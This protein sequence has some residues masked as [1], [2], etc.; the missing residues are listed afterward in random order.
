MKKLFF[1]LLCLVI[2]NSF[3]SANEETVLKAGY[4]KE[5]G[6]TPAVI[7]I[8]KLDPASTV[9]ELEEQKGT[10][11]EAYLYFI[12]PDGE[13]W[14]KKV[15]SYVIPVYEW[16]VNQPEKLSQFNKLEIYFN[17]ER[18]SNPFNVGYMNVKFTER[19]F[20]EEPV[21]AAIQV[22]KNGEVIP[23][24]FDMDQV[25]GAD[26][27]WVEIGVEEP[28]SIKV[29][30][31]NPDRGLQPSSISGSPI[32]FQGGTFKRMYSDI[33]NENSTGYDAGLYLE[34]PLGVED[35]GTFTK[36]QVSIGP[37]DDIGSDATL[38]AMN[39][40]VFLKTMTQEDRAAIAAKAKEAQK[41]MDKVW[42]IFYVLLAIGIV[43]SY[44]LV[45][46]I[47]KPRATQL[48]SFRFLW[49]L[50]GTRIFYTLVSVGWIAIV[51]LLWKSPLIPGNAISDLGI[52]MISFLPIIFLVIEPL[53]L[54]KKYKRCSNCK[55][56]VSPDFIGT[57]GL[58]GSRTKHTAKLGDERISTGTETHSYSADHFECPNCGADMSRYYSMHSGG[59]ADVRVGNDGKMSTDL[60]NTH[61]FFNFVL[62][63]AQ[64][65]K[66]Y[67]FYRKIGLLK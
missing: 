20:V 6:H 65:Y 49:L 22:T 33:L 58:G 28:V 42:N 55:A 63:L 53:Q 5:E 62:N 19:P 9:I 34:Q 26:F 60:M 64:P 35:R 48:A 11:H 37:S 54:D 32:S 41:N 27:V 31:T 45:R 61:A 59:K 52:L 47:Y 56:Y 67:R 43:G 17:G 40:T 51:W 12:K 8:S 14:S 21:T 30:R 2:L 4:D 23:A 66:W 16:F 15:S 25:R 24:E 46:L 10:Y 7:E 38:P 1:V 13:E 36:V 29:T 50:S 18:G 3:L 39:G 44:L 57:Q